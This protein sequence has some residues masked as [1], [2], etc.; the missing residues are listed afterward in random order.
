MIY[1]KK[2]YRKE[3]FLP[4]KLITRITEDIFNKNEYEYRTKNNFLKCIGIIYHK[5]IHDCLSLDQFVPV[6]RDYWRKV[7]SSDYHKKVIKPLIDLNIIERKDFLYRSVYVGI[8]YRINPELINE[9]CETISYIQKGRVIS[10]EES[11]YGNGLEFFIEEI[12]DKDFHLSIDQEKANSFLEHNA[13]VI[14]N[15][16]LHPEYISSLSDKLFIE[17]HEVLEK[18]SYNTRFSTVEFA[19]IYAETYHKQ[20][21]YFKDTFYIGNIDDFIKH[22]IPALKHHYKNQLAKIGLLPII[23]KRNLVNLRLH[24]NLVTFPSKILQFIMINNQTIVQFDLRT[25]Q[26]L[27]FANLLNVFIT[28]GEIELL[29]LFKHPKTLGYVKRLIRVMKKHDK[30]LPK[31]GL[32][33]TDNNSGQNSSSDVIKFIRDVFT[34]DFYSVVQVELGLPSRGLAKQVL[35]KLLFKKTNRRDILV[36]KLKEHYPVVM[37]IIAGFKKQIKSQSKE[38]KS[39]NDDDRESY[40]S[41]FLQCV[42]AEIFIDNI[43]IPLRD[44]GIP[45]FTRH[46]SVVVAQGY[47]NEVESFVKDVFARFGF[48]YNHKVEDKFW[49]IV[50]YDEL[51]ESPYLEWLI[52]ENEL[53]TD[54]SIDDQEVRDE[55]ILIEDNMDEFY[56]FEE[57]H[58]E[59]ISRLQRIGLR[60][61]YFKY[62][63]ASFLEDISELPFLSDEEITILLDDISNI[64]VGYNYLQDETNKLLRQIVDTILGFTLP[65]EED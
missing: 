23:N 41:V 4:K 15:E 35:F 9:D 17:Y 40:F 16:Y 50:D 5:Q 38:S 31:V 63:D 25:S 49:E 44:K 24:N 39:I 26:F 29:S 53:N 62:V 51:E 61:N 55:N 10:A 57:H 58:Y 7:Y 36:D 18:G 54:F 64:S 42:E 33:I 52:G 8:R 56:D 12:S 32:D 48:K 14:C 27:L 37:S 34:K 3:E 60:N 65:E 30:L 59:T 20:L 19:K 1:R 21:F 28:K 47:Q 22:R 13:D 2:A 43:L 6:G 45:C 46:D 11:I